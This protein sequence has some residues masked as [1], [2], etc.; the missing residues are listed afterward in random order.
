MTGHYSAKLT[1]LA[2]DRLHWFNSCSRSSTLARSL[3]LST[4]AT[5]HFCSQ[6]VGRCS[7]PP[8][9]S[10]AWRTIHTYTSTYSFSPIEPLYW[11]LPILGCATMDFRKI[12][13]TTSLPPRERRPINKR[14][15][16]IAT[17]KAQAASNKPQ[18][19]TKAKMLQKTASLISLKVAAVKRA[20]AVSSSIPGTVAASSGVD[21]APEL[22]RNLAVASDTTSLGIRKYN[23]RP[24][25]DKAYHADCPPEFV[26]RRTE[27]NYTAVPVRRLPGHEGV[28]LMI[29]AIIATNYLCT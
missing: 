11:L 6:L 22:E 9:Q 23:L 25:H 19:T 3:Y 26:E 29:F 2:M 5:I 12:T 14:K 28:T 18:T 20:K 27:P 21:V 24:N 10:P 16:A 1:K 17:A 8:V 7:Q 13:K 15:R 4:C